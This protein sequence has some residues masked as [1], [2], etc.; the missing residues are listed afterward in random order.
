MKLRPTEATMRSWAR[1][2]GWGWVAVALFGLGLA[3]SIGE[4]QPQARSPVRAASSAPASRPERVVLI[5]IDGARAGAESWPE[6]MPAL[7]RLTRQGARFRYAT[8]PSPITVPATAAVLSGRMSPPSAAGGA[9][10][11]DGRSWLAARLA[12]AGYTT[13]AL[14][15]DRG[16]HGR[17][18]SARGFQTFETLSASFDDSARVDT[19]LAHLGRSGRH[20]VWLGFSFGQPIEPW[21]RLRG[22]GFADSAAYAARARAID[23]ALGR[24]AAGIDLAR[25]GPRS[26]L[27]V[28]VGTHGEAVPGWPLRR[29]GFEESALPG[30][31]ADLSEDALRVP[32]V[33][34]GA[35]VSAGSGSSTREPW[36]S[37]LDVA[38]T[39][40]AAGGATLSADGVSLWPL[41]RGGTL[42]PRVLVHETDGA[43]WLGGP[44]R[45]AARQGRVKR[46]ACGTERA[47]LVAPEGAVPSGRPTTARLERAIDARRATVAS[48]PDSVAKPADPM[49][50]ADVATA[51]TELLAGLPAFGVSLDS[52]HL[53]RLSALHERWPNAPLIELEQTVA[54]SLAGYDHPAAR[55]FLDL[56]K[57]HPAFEEVTIA[58]ADHLRRHEHGELV[59]DALSA[60]PVTSP[61]AADALWRLAIGHAMR[62]EFDQALPAY[63]EARAL[64]SPPDPHWNHSYPAFLR[65]ADLHAAVNAAP[66]SASRRIEY[67]RALYAFGLGQKAYPQLHRARL[68][69]PSNPEP[70]YWMGAFLLEEGRP[71]PALNALARALEVAPHHVPSLLSSAEAMAVLGRNADALAY[72]RKAVELHG[73]DARARF[74][75]ACL[76]ARVGDTAAAAAEL[77][78]AVAAGYDN[79]EQI[80]TDPD[81]ERV[82][83]TESYRRLEETRRGS[84]N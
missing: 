76:L 27:L 28:I 67:A 33:L 56:R 11:A 52:T 12:T 38:P 50:C 71:E 57:R 54:F 79:W 4:A 80:A 53:E 77:E 74:N 41:L 55:T 1:R 2:T 23:D 37:T 32:L 58:Y 43:R 30:H 65:I 16:T 44:H 31:G 51:W 21:R 72:Q 75:L 14:P 69:D 15:A 36:V 17:V 64:G 20:F 8:T 62:M 29:A 40:A 25:S 39:V 35:G 13:L 82:R 18:P 47:D 24:L 60:V 66:D 7:A 34:V 26:T 10:D 61:L 83:A 70:N 78:R 5:T 49:T 48:A 81:L 84:R 73:N 19:A 59:P 63:R 22:A 42:P 6:V 46:V 45:I 3:A 9:A 68:S